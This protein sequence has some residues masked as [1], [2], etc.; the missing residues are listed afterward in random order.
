MESAEQLLCA[1]QE[2]YGGE[3]LPFRFLCRRTWAKQL[4]SLTFRPFKP[5]IYSS[6]K[7]LNLENTVQP[8]TDEG[9]TWK[10]I[11][12]KRISRR[13]EGL[14][15][16]FVRQSPGNQ[17]LTADTA[18]CPWNAPGKNVGVVCHFLLEG[19]FLPRDY[20]MSPALAGRFLT[21]M[22]GG[23]GCSLWCNQA[24]RS[25]EILSWVKGKG[26]WPS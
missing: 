2:F 5:V 24:Q 25:L 17:L 3:N 13:G 15:Y 19:I 1:E 11:C 21:K 18:L 20:I 12:R 6:R 9:Q 10:Q 8:L 14:P 16:G 22:E 23:R 7:W 26:S 4:Y